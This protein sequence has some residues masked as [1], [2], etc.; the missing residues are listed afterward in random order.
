[1]AV[2]WWVRREPRGVVPSGGAGQALQGR[3]GLATERWRRAWQGP[4]YPPSLPSRPA[5]LPI[6]TSVPFA[7]GAPSLSFLFRGAAL[8]AGDDATLA[9]CEVYPGDT[10]RVVGAAV[11]VPPS[12]ERLLPLPV[13]C[14]CPCSLALWRPVSIP[15]P[16]G[17]SWQL[18]VAARAC[19]CVREPT[20]RHQ[21]LR[22]CC[23]CPWASTASLQVDSGVHD[24][25]D[26]ASVLAFGVG[27]AQGGKG[28][29][30]AAGAEA[31]LGGGP[32]SCQRAPP[33]L[34]VQAHGTP[35][36]AFASTHG[37]VW[38]Q[39]VLPQLTSTFL[40]PAWFCACRAARGGAGVHRHRPHRPALGRPGRRQQRRRRRGGRGFGG[41]G[42]YGG[43]GGS[44]WVFCVPGAAPDPP[45]LRYVPLVNSADPRLCS[46][47]ALLPALLVP[48]V[49]MLAPPDQDIRSPAPRV[50]LW[51]NF[52]RPHRHGR[53][54]GGG[55]GGR[56][57]RRAG[58]HDG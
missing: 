46:R 35:A 44:R 27:P 42:R 2:G 40:P 36:A 39:P 25:S 5:L 32:G 14:Y 58:G 16:A 55:G 31:R 57:G 30:Q 34:G 12:A 41:R 13:E 17:S 15:G 45:N 53:R 28:E 49:F 29:R 24:S 19:Q 7:A 22:P 1:M 26:Y 10:I 23:P 47:Q 11:A 38:L 48:A 51:H 56:A 43:P 37:G 9:Q 6:D 3:A 52:C 50:P 18:S 4:S 20:R 21:L 33:C 8:T 54:A